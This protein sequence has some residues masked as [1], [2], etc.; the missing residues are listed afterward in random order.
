MEKEIQFSDE[1]TNEEDTVDI[2][3][4]LDAEYELQE[5]LEELDIEDDASFDF[6]YHG[7]KS[8]NRASVIG[9]E[10]AG[11][12]I[13]FR[14]LFKGD[15]K[16]VG[17]PWPEEPTLESPLVRIARWNG[18]TL[19][20]LADIDEIPIGETDGDYFVFVPQPPIGK[21]N[22]ELV[23]PSGKTL[24]KKIPSIPY[25]STQ[26]VS[27]TVTTRFLQ[28]PVFKFYSSE[29]DTYHPDIN[30]RF[31]LLTIIISSVIAPVFIPIATSISSVLG[32]LLMGFIMGSF[33]L[34]MFLSPIVLMS[35]FDY[36]E[37]ESPED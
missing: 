5:Q 1:T 22:F 7:I 28:T 2:E 37:M 12:E 32:T 4:L 17:I 11:D 20:R 14:L 8:I 13:R 31:L 30:P 16:E 3:R 9:G 10:K 18:T 15:E 36:F 21:Q 27:D 25:N 29:N 35:D 6:S 24:R 23:L 33:F 19:D 26:W 34:I